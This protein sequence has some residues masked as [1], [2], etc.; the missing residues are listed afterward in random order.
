MDCLCGL[1]AQS[2]TVLKPGANNG[3]EFLTCA[4][5]PNQCKFFHWVIPMAHDKVFPSKENAKPKLNFS[6]KKPTPPPPA[7]AAPI[8]TLPTTDPEILE[9]IKLGRIATENIFELLQTTLME[10]Q[11]DMKEKRQRRAD[12]NKRPLKRQKVEV[13]EQKTQ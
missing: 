1:P 4:Y 13:E 7:A 11:Q 6:Y 10:W 12:K 8:P 2:K 5:T 3:R 9:D